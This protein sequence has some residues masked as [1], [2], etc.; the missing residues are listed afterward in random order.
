MNAPA[1]VERSVTIANDAESLI[2]LLRLRT[3]EVASK[4]ILKA[5][6]FGVV[7]LTLDKGQTMSEHEAAVPILIQVLSGVVDIEVDGAPERFETGGIIYIAA[8]VRHALHAVE[9]AH[10]LLA[11]ADAATRAPSDRAG[12]GGT[13][14]GRAD[15]AA[16]PEQDRDGADRAHAPSPEHRPLWNRAIAGA[17][18]H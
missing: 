3:D 5:P 12:V 16:E 14:V 6:G 15:A 4:R 13:E 17:R 11:L 9:S 1:A 2:D 18:A 10:V 8:H 7:R